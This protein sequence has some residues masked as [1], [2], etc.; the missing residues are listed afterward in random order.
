M[1]LAVEAKVER[2]VTDNWVDIQKGDLDAA[3]VEFTTAL[4]G[5][6]FT[7]G[8]CHLSRDASCGPDRKGQHAYLLERKKFDE[9]FH[10]DLREG[11]IA[12]ALRDVTQQALEALALVD[13]EKLDDRE[14]NE[15]PTTEVK[16]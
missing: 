4:P 16:I 12:E 1:A 10:A 13:A 7:V 6:W 15:T 14:W 11:T 5:W 9:G 3:I 2:L 8:A